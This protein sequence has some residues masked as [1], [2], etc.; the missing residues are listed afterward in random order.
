MRGR[1]AGLFHGRRYL[2]CA[3]GWLHLAPLGEEAGSPE[4]TRCG[5]P[6][7]LMELASQAAV[8]AVPTGV[9]VSVVRW[10]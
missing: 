3:C 8:D 7:H 10:P 1:L 9:T 6:S 5:R 4:C 2:I